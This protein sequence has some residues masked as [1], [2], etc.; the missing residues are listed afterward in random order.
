M[1]TESG[2]G[3]VLGSCENSH[4]YLASLKSQKFLKVWSSRQISIYKSILILFQILFLHYISDCILPTCNDITSSEKYW[5]NALFA[6]HKATDA[7][8]ISHHCEDVKVKA[9]F[10]RLK[11][12]WLFSLC[13]NWLIKAAYLNYLATFMTEQVSLTNFR[14]HGMYYVM[15]CTLQFMHENYPIKKCLPSR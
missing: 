4:V 7:T 2:Y 12:W 9:S 5:L 11:S 15:L 6:L 14:V 8:Q 3:S 13:S 10:H 1:W